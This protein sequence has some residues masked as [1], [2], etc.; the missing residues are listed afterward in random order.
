MPRLL[1]NLIAPLLPALIPLVLLAACAS[2]PAREA[3]DACDAARRGDIPEAIT[4]ADK[5]Y[6]QFDKLTTDDLCRL[7]ASY[8]V[9]ALSTGDINAADRFQEAYKSS[10]STDSKEANEFYA[11]LDPQMSEG[12][13]IISG[14]LDGQGIYTTASSA[15]HQAIHSTAAEESA[16]IANQA[17]AED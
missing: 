12:L 10:L 14:L 5:A 17:L 6:A 2:T 3:A 11:S 15:P 4:A 7:A 8:A 9:I 16:D 13:K 1:V